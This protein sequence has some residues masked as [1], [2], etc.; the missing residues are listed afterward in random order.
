MRAISVVGILTLV[1]SLDACGARTPLGAED[2]VADTDPDGGAANGGAPHTDGDGGDGADGG[3]GA[4]GTGGAPI[5]A[6]PQCLCENLPGYAACVLPLMCCP[7]VATCEDPAHF[8][9]S[10][11]QTLF[12]DEQPK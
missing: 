6:T 4:G 9:C 3:G 11:S 10:G 7:V 5:P 2:T 1:A 12:C 8:N